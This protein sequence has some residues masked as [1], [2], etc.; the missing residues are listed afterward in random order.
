M[1]PPEPM[2]QAGMVRQ[3]R[4]HLDFPDYPNHAMSDPLYRLANEK[5]IRVILT[6]LG[7]DD[8]LGEG[9]PPYADLLR[10]GKLRACLRAFRKDSDEP[11]SI[12]KGLLATFLPKPVH[13]AYLGSIPALRVVSVWPIGSA[14]SQRRRNS[15]AMLN[16][17]SSLPPWTG[18]GPMPTT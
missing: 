6:G 18:N 3:I 1:L 15:A 7:G 12:F 2:D 5:G 8:W 14:T 17:I 16:A 13:R 4:Q 11:L 9:F 10:Q